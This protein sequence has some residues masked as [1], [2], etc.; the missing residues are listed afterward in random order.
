MRPEIARNSLRALLIGCAAT[1][2]GP[3]FAQP[4]LDPAEVNAARLGEERPVAGERH[5]LIL[6]LQVLLDRANVSPGVVDGYLG[7]NVEKALSAYA[8]REGFA[9]AD[10]L[11]PEIV[12]ALLAGDVEPVLERYV[13]T[14][15][16]LEGPFVES[17][18]DD[19]AQLAE[20]ERLAYRGPQEMLAE[21]FHMDQE[22]LE[23]LNPDADFGS[24]GTEILVARP[25]E[26]LEEGTIA[27]IAVDRSLGALRAL[28]EAG[29]IV[30][31]Y[32]ATIGSAE[33]PS[34]SGTHEI[35][36][37]AMDPAYY[38]RP[39]VNF[40]QGDL[41][42]QL[43]IPPGP[44]NPVGTVWIDL[45]EPTYGIHG[46]PTPDEIDKDYSH[47]CVRLTNWDAEELAGLVEQGIPVEFV[48]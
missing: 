23:A 35:V 9:D 46:T 2:A 12:E 39:D 38:Y 19:Y 21:R 48:Q 27:R 5:P 25:G 30:V 4:A 31:F 10:P 32:P 37:V 33:T 36:A 44:N 17:I 40:Q 18:P 42:R 29:E 6:R 14:A 7:E 8:R 43:E 22:L 11:A 3:A 45:S 16:D 34:P 26:A 1:F 13:I 28:D 15:D 47:G 24:A 41:D 20:M